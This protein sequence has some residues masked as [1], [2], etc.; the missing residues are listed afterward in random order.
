MPPALNLKYPN[1]KFFLASVAIYSSK[2][3]NILAQNVLGEKHQ[4]YSVT[5]KTKILLHKMFLVR[6]IS[7]TL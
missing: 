1:I 7:D 4:K 6:N 5:V 2:K 3:L